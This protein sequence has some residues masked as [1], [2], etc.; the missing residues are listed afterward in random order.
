MKLLRFDD[1]PVFTPNLAKFGPRTFESTH[2]GNLTPTPL[3]HRW[4]IA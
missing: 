1:C 3:K 4:K 2:I